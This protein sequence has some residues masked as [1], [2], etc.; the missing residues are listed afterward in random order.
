MSVSEMVGDP[1][2]VE[3]V[4]AP[5]R[6]N[7]FHLEPRCRVCRNDEMRRKVN[8]QLASGASYAMIARAIGE[9]NAAGV[10]LDSIRRHAERHFPVQNVAKATYR[11]VLERRAQENGVDFVNGLATALTPM[12]F[13]ECVMNDAFRRLVDGG[14]DVGVDTGLRAAEK[15]QTLIDTRA[16]QADIAGMRAEMGRI[17]EVVR[18]FIPSERWPELQA[19]VH[20]ETPT[21]RQQPQ[22]VER[23]RALCRSTTPRMRTATDG[24]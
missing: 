17:I 12:A 18:T 16:G 3:S 6:V 24:R 13:Y 15:L 14:V 4:G 20:G 1:V 9:D 21:R 8:D 10:T 23:V 19:A 7:G 22:V 11:E 5:A 2:D